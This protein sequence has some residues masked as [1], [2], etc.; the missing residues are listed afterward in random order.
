MGLFTNDPTEERA[1]A[2]SGSADVE[3]ADAAV[4]RATNFSGRLELGRGTAHSH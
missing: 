3:H 2:A 1:A 4:G